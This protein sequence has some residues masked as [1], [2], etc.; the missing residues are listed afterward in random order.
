MHYLVE[1]SFSSIF[2]LF[3]C[4]ERD[5]VEKFIKPSLPEYYPTS[6]LFNIKCNITTIG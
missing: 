4:I 5:S 3:S 6:L 1:I 2:H